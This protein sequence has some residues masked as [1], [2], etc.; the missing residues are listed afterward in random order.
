MHAQGGLFMVVVLSVC[1]STLILALQDTRRPM[2]DTNCFRTM[3]TWKTKWQFSWN[4]F[5]R[6]ISLESKSLYVAS[7]WS[8][9]SVY[10]GGTRSHNRGHVST[11]ACYL[12]YCIEV[13][14]HTYHSLRQLNGVFPIA[15]GGSSLVHLCTLVVKETCEQWQKNW[16]NEHMLLIYGHYAPKLYCMCMP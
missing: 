13:Q 9:R 4:D 1:L 7:T 15:Y 5:V 3:Q 11:P 2:S 14:S 6:E 8:T 10:P 12:L 16:G